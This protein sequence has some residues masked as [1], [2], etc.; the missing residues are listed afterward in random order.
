VCLCKT[1]PAPN[2]SLPAS[3]DCVVLS[4]FAGRRKMMNDELA[5]IKKSLRLIKAYALLMTALFMVMGFAGFTQSGPKQNF[6][7]ITAKRL[8]IVDSNGKGRVLLASDYK[9]DNSAGLFFFNQE[10]TESGAFFY[11]GKRDKDGKIDAYSLLTMDQFK[12]DQ[13]VALEYDHNG[14]QKRQ[15]LTISDRPDALSPQAEELLR[16]LGQALQSAKSEAESQAIRRDYLSRLP[17]RDVVARRLF[18]GRDVE[19]ASLVTLSDPDGKP[20]L[21]LKVD[22]LGQ[23]SITFLDPSGK[24][25]RTIKP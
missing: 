9:K 7:E 22:K 14:D 8:L 13:I 6:E 16:A 24:A 18:A 21:R 20:R 17:A 4:S 5:T 2:Q 12:S 3:R 23:P 25:V 19:G 11:N 10:G 1:G 15:G